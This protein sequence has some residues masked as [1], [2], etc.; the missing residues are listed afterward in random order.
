M[1]GALTANHA[2]LITLISH[3]GSCASSM[4]EKESW[5]RSTTLLV[6]IY[7]GIKLGIFTF[8]FAPQSHHVNHA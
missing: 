1:S 5:I 4:S 7:E 6:L 3:F 2:K 8:D